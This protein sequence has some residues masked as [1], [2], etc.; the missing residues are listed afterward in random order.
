MD[1]SIAT[2]RIRYFDLLNDLLNDD[3]Y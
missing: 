2:I 3:Y 1:R